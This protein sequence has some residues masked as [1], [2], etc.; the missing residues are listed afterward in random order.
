MPILSEQA[1][2][3]EA[4]GRLQ[5]AAYRQAELQVGHQQIWCAERTHPNED[6]PWL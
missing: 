3:Y 5:Q 1:H 4:A 6:N 2:H